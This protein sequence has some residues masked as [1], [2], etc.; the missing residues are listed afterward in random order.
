MPAIAPASENGVSHSDSPRSASREAR[1]FSDNAR[2]RATLSNMVLLSTS[3]RALVFLAGG[4]MLADRIIGF[5]M[6]LP[7]MFA[8][9]WLGNR[10]HARVSRVQMVRLISAL[11]VLIGVSL[12]ARVV[13]QP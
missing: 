11:L 6:L 5:L 8:G 1:R 10:L 4:L 3:I 12:L 7:F 2:L 13:S 9:L